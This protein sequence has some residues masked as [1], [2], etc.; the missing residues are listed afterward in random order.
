MGFSKPSP[1]TVSGYVGTTNA[2]ISF[3]GNLQ[4]ALLVC[5]QGSTRLLRTAKRTSSLKLP[6]SILRM[7]WFR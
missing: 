6:K 7:I 4:P 3:P 2:V 1:K 5:P